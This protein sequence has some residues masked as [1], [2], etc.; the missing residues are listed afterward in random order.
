MNEPIYIDLQLKGKGFSPSKFGASIGLAIEPIV[1]SGEIGKVGRYRGM[2]IPYGIGLL[3]LEPREEAILPYAKILL[4]NKKALK[5]NNVEEI[6]FD[7]DATPQRLENFSITPIIAR[8]I[9]ML[10][11]RIQFHSIEE[12]D[13]NDFSDVLNKLTSKMSSSR[14]IP[15]SKL[16]A[17][18]LKNIDT[19]KYKGHV[20]SEYMYSLF[21]YIFENMGDKVEKPTFD[22]VIREY[23]KIS[24]E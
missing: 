16:V 10:N 13:E 9:A 8:M 4:K 21:V 11:A 19:N 18:L 6:I 20:S 5:E 12:E 1:E 7:V 15:Q 24:Q 23:S 14:K 22:K 17:F 3:R 2:N